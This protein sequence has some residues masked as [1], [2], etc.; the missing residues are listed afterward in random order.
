[1]L[2]SFSLKINTQPELDNEVQ[3]TGYVALNLVKFKE[4]HPLH[5]DTEYSDEEYEEG[6]EVE[7][8]HTAAFKDLT[9]HDI[10]KVGV[11]V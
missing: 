9:S 10:Y 7:I 11:V 4:G 1:L 8:D 6:D 5:E 2:Q 3:K